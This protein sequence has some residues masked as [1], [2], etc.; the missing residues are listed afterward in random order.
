MAVAELITNRYKG[1]TTPQIV[2][3]HDNN[4]KYIAIIAQEGE[5]T[6]S[7]G[8]VDHSKSFFKIASGNMFET[9]INNISQFK[10]SGENT[11]L[12]VIQDV[13]SKIVSSYDGYVLTYDDVVLTF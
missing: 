8:K 10:Y 13:D 12:S 6:I 11:Y 2:A 5:V 4:R 3:V 1:S 7:I 9:L